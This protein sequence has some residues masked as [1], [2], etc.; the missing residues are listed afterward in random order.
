MR[1]KLSVSRDL[2]AELVQRDRALVVLRALVA[3]DP[4]AAWELQVPQAVSRASGHHPG[5]VQVVPWGCQGHL[6]A[7][8]EVA[9][10][11]LK[12]ACSRSSPS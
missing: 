11:Y 10:Q 8:V 3:P 12:M 1:W 5:M 4:R 2:R 9:L 7:L 6:E